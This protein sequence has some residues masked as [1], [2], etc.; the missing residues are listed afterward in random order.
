MVRLLLLSTLLLVAPAFVAGEE[1]T[2]LPTVVVEESYVS[3]PLNYPTAFSTTINMDDF[4][5]EYKTTS[6]LLNFSP[7]V[8]VRDFGGF[9]QLKTLSI[10]GSSNDQ[11]VILLDGI[12]ISS[13]IGGGVDLSTIPIDYVE[14]FE[15][16]RGGATALAGSDAIGGVVNIITRP[17]S[18]E[19][20]KGSVTFGSFG[21]FSTNLFRSGK[22]GHF[23][24]LV[25][26]THSQSNGDFKFRSINGFEVERINNEFVSESVLLKGA[27]KMP[28]GWKVTALNEFY[29]DDKGVPGLGEFQEASSNQRD[30]RNLTSLQFTKES[31]LKD[32]L[33]LDI[34]IFHRFDLLEFENK[35]P[36][37][38][39][40][41]DTLSRL[42]AFGANPS[43]TWYISPAHTLTTSV[44]LRE[45][46]LKNP[47]FDNPKR[48]TLSAFMGDEIE[49]FENLLFINPIVRFDLLSTR[50]DKTDTEAKFSPKL[51]I[52]A[53]PLRHLSFKTNLGRS[54][55]APSFGELFFPEQG[56]IGGNP[57]LKSESS[58]DFDV[59][60]V[61]GHPK[62]GLELNY[63]RNHIDDLILFVFVSANRIEPRNVGDVV[64]QGIEASIVARP[65]DFLELFASYTLLDGEI[66]D[67]GAQL[68]GR[69][70]NKL[71][72]R[73]VLKHGPVKLFWEIEFTDSIP[74]TAFKNS[75]ETEAR[76]THGLGIKVDWKKLF[77]T[78]EI[79]NLTN[80]EEVRDAFDFPL[81]GRRA[82]F[83]LGFKL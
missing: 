27:Y 31:F 11:V 62:L 34:K 14:R 3:P 22:L 79:K 56:F 16:I 50:E 24:Y 17:T 66:D 15:I 33:D 36:T 8:Q 61:F 10:R 19:L 54:F 43:L 7:G 80:N 21:T 13:P 49:L 53:R 47:D 51:G 63:F 45:E 35:E 4:G 73:T 71:N 68:P 12:R 9:G 78:F 25:S 55:R 48:F 75:R 70:K 57:D 82:F 18:E 6:E 20:T 2:T 72:A 64:E 83:T 67:T 28:S 77:A 30:V 23:E 69:P 40:P 32:N 44:E 41:I 60:A 65:Y 76:T 52:I 81:P 29:F 74:L 5:G 37:L 59:G 58:I 39:I 46:I 26:A 38:G 42:F 1:P